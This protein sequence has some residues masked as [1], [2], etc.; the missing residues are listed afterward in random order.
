MIKELLEGARKPV[1]LCSFGKDSLLLLSM[2]QEV[3]PDIDVL[4]F[5]QDT[6]NQQW[7]KHYI[8]EHNLKVFSYAPADK[9]FLPEGDDLVLVHE[10]DTGREKLSMI[11][12]IGHSD[13]CGLQLNKQRTPNFPWPWDLALV[14]WKKSDDP[15]IAL[16]IPQETTLTDTRVVAPLWEYTDTDVWEEIE[17]RGIDTPMAI[18][19]VRCCTNCVKS[20]DSMVFCPL[21]G[22][23]IPTHQ[24]DKQAALTAFQQ[25]LSEE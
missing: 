10:Y 20:T 5:R 1:V 17:L 12:E 6:A 14:G 25:R 24:W 21:E 9:Y 23:T 16:S 11:M 8:K 22:K 18:P 7:A 15:S 3:N 2:A 4:W 19:D 13:D